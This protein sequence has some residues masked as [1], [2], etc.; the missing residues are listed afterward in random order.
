MLILRVAAVSVCYYLAAQVAFLLTYPG[1][2]SPIIYFPAAISIFAALI[3]GPTG[4]IA[5]FCGAL[6]T[7]LSQYLPT[8]PKLWSPFLSQTFAGPI[9]AL[10]CYLILNYVRGRNK[11]LVVLI[12]ISGVVFAGIVGAS[13]GAPS[14]HIAGIIQNEAIP[15]SIALWASA[16]ILGLLLGILFYMIIANYGGRFK[17][18]YNS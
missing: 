7:V 12:G 4:L 1:T 2:Y 8:E 6:I 14:L 15:K 17:K 16:D 13:I 5:V 18:L 3:Y 11:L 10:I 9:E